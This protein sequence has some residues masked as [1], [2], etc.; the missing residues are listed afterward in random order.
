MT[1]SGAEGHGAQCTSR[2]YI[3]LLLYAAGF[4]TMIASWQMMY[5]GFDVDFDCRFMF[6]W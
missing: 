2:P 3:L 4:H 6:T 5:V 1:S